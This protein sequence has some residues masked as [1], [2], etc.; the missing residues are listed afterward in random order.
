MRFSPESYM[1]TY[2][3]AVIGS[4]TK[5]NYGHDLDKVWQL[6]PGCQV[7]AVADDSKTGLEAEMKRL[8]VAKGYLNYV[9]MLDKEK[10][11]FVSICQRWLDRHAEMAIAAAERGIHIYL[12][13]PM[14]RSMKEADAIVAACEKHKVKLAIA[15]QTRYSPRLPVVKNLLR[16]GRIGKVLE[17]RARGKEDSRGGGEDLWVLGTHLF[18]MIHHLGGEPTWCMAR[19]FEGGKPITK[20]NVRNGAEGIGPLAGDEVHAV[21]GLADGAIA[22]FDSVRNAGGNPSRFGLQ[23]V[24]S[25]GVLEVLM[26]YLPSVKLLEDP[27]W[28]PGRSG[29]PWVDVSSAGVGKPE[30]LKDGSLLA[31]NVAAVKDLIAAV[32][33]DRQP[34]A[35][36]YEA[37]TSTEMIVAA[38]ESHRV[39]APV[40]L[41]L[42]NRENPLTMLE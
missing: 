24:G 5:G 11:Q 9:E 2:R 19:V 35:S 10:P 26:G 15:F 13:K 28:S 3:A 12:E 36:M 32:E 25:K 6:I 37:R 40:T 14:C 29:K 23:I 33:N 31:G 30:E 4:T 18:N 39:G 16:E 42:M 20:A 1:P 8:N 7:V 17:F 41:P 27:S 22:T 21:Y 38:F 34:E